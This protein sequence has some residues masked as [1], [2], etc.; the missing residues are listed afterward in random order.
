MNV[1][2]GGTR[3]SRVF[4][5]SLLMLSVAT[6]EGAPAG[7]P[8]AALSNAAPIL[9][10]LGKQI[11]DQHRSEAE[12][13]DLIRTLG[14]W[15][16]AQVRPPLLITLNDPLASIRTASAQALGWP[17]NK[18]AVSALRDR[19]V[20]PN[21]TSAV[22]AA[23]LESLGRIGDDAGRAVVLASVRDPDDK[24]RRAALWAV[25]FGAL[26]KRADRMPF[27]RQ[28]AE[29]RGM[30][31]RIRCE[32]IGA[33]GEAKDA[34]ATELLM[35]LLAHEP[36]IPMPLPR[37]GADQQE[38]MM[39]RYREARDVRAW[40]A[41]ALGLMKAKAALPL[42]LK[43]AEDPDDFFLRLA[44]MQV[45]VSWKVPEAQPVLIRRLGDSFADNRQ[46]ALVG[47]AQTGDR[48]MVDAVTALLS[49]P[50]P[51]VR[52]QA[53]IAL[54]DLGDPRVRPDL[55]ALRHTEASPDVQQALDQALARL[56]H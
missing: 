52:A 24:I 14:D 31:L 26:A 6:S 39:A 46:T 44:S 11:Q 48:S 28:L 9:E 3:W 43:S 20:M 25:T 33:L 45:L 7:Q 35:R 30:D 17:G 1:E 47:L 32:A 27:L 5:V 53:V 16:T 42:L 56:P 34:D 8:G 23:A 10:E 15:G 37:E 41:G 55:E 49:D 51:R 2:R 40:A 4:L 38:V 19:I 22:K 18:E 50:V 36:P 29:D 13:L 12:R 54:G 21:E